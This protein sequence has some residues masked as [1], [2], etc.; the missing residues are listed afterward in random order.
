MGE[1]IKG[2]FTQN[3]HHEPTPDVSPPTYLLSDIVSA[4]EITTIYDSRCD[5]AILSLEQLLLLL[6]DDLRSRDG[7]LTSVELDQYFAWL[8]SI[9]D[10]TKPHTPPQS[11]PPSDYPPLTVVQ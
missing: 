6:N 8:N 2:R 3:L 10:M 4:D 5:L 7:T 9:I 1:L 11:S